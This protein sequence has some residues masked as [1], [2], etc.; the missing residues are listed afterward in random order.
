MRAALPLRGDAFLS[1]FYGVLSLGLSIRPD[2]PEAFTAFLPPSWLMGWG[3]L[4][5]QCIAKNRSA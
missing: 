2:G 3:I 5:R 1:S 4:E